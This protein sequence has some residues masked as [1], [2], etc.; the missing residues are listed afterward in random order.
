[1]AMSGAV[2]TSREADVVPWGISGT[3]TESDWLNR[4]MM[5][6]RA[7]DPEALGELY[8]HTVAKVM[9][10]ARG[11]LRDRA[12]AEELVCDVYHRAWLRADSFD[13]ERGSALAW[14]MIMCRSG[15]LDR[16]RR[17]R[18]LE[19]Q[20]SWALGYATEASSPPCPENVL[21]HFQRGHA[22]QVALA[23]ISPLRRRMIALAYFED[24]S[25]QEIAT[26]LEMPLGTV[27]SHLRRGLA[28]LRDL[29]GLNE[30]HDE[31]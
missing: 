9:A 17:R 19:A 25:Q 21:H 11:M 27:K 1:M 18:R 30:A 29:L 4:V 14:L 26:Q 5:R 23:A 12:D 6:V 31:T 10:L 16:M 2:E 28:E 8:D 24:L 15:A 20:S 3:R 22:V 13:P 7:R